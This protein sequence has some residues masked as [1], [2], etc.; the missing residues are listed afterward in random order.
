MLWSER[1][2]INNVD[3]VLK[4]ISEDQLAFFNKGGQ[5]QIKTKEVK[6]NNQYYENFSV[7]KW[8]KKRMPQKEL[9][10]VASKVLMHNN[11][12]AE[13]RDFITVLA[14][15]SGHYPALCQGKWYLQIAGIDY[16]NFVQQ[17]IREEWKANDK[18]ILEER[19]YSIGNPNNKAILNLKP[20]DLHRT[21]MNTYSMYRRWVFNEYSSY[22]ARRGNGLGEEWKFTYTGLEC[23]DWI[24]HNIDW[25]KVIT[26]DIKKH[27]EEVRSNN[28][29]DSFITPYVTI[30]DHTGIDS[31]YDADE[32]I[33]WNNVNWGD[34]TNEDDNTST[35]NEPEK[36][37]WVIE[38]Y[39]I[40]IAIF[41][42]FNQCDFRKKSCGGCIEKE[43]QANG[44]I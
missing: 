25:L 26:Q 16:S 12:N 10:K 4:E 44:W 19:Q 27:I 7:K 9:Y 36:D 37:P 3:P 32:D 43:A 38:E 1:V 40:W 28:R 17:Q 42:A 6:Y 11:N 29:D 21:D 23:D 22:N 5:P 13:C 18:K 34:E 31:G 2:Y 24:K 14:Y 35:L 41:K 39:D 15:W 8:Y 30:N 20:N 33:D